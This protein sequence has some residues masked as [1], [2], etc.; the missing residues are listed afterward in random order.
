LNQK[1]KKILVALDGSELAEEA[2]DPAVAL[3]AQDGAELHLISVIW[4]VPPVSM[5]LASETVISG[6]IGEEKAKAQEYLDR[7]ADKARA[8]SPNVSVSTHVRRGEVSS[9]V[10]AVA[11]ELNV[12]L[13]VLTTHGRGALK[14]SALGSTADRLL[15]SV[16]RPLLL[17]RHPQTNVWAF[18]PETLRHVLVPLDGSDAAE[19]ALDALLMVLPEGGGPRVTL[20]RVIDEK[21]HIPMIYIAEAVSEEGL[22]EKHRQHAETYLEQASSQL[23]SKGIA[24]VEGQVI[25][26]DDPGRGLIRLC[27]EVGVELIV[28]STHGRGGVPRFF[29]GSVAADLI[30]GAPVPVL[31]TRRP[32]PA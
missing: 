5:A 27:N 4:Q 16:E 23:K 1:L 10:R 30:R 19:S 14:R 3:A 22:R 26:D 25:V 28:I 7:T 18:D 21:Y 6:W 2:L 12:D 29:L 15:R 11:E 17:L 24:N 8:R 32:E 13:V 9:T 31:V 20:A